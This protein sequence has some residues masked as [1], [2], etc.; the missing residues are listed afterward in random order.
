MMAESASRA[1]WQGPSGFSFE[2]ISTASG[3]C[4]RRRDAA[5]S[6]GSVIP[7]K[8]AAAEAAADRSR[9][10]R[11]EKRGMGTSAW[12]CISVGV[13][14]AGQPAPH[15]LVFFTSGVIARPGL[16]LVVLLVLDLQL[17]VAAINL[18]ILPV[19]SD[20]TLP[21]HFPTVLPECPP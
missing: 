8:A 9:K 11:P 16:D 19:Q 5:A 17:A 3:A 10:E 14:R 6:I 20:F 18:V 1:A 7:R 2:S 12:E 15:A 21:P 4:G 13:E